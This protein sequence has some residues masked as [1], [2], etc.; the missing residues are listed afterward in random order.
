LSP[1]PSEL[2]NPVLMDFAYA[3]PTATLAGETLQDFV[4]SL[5]APN[6]TSMSLV[7]FNANI[8][9]LFDEGDQLFFVVTGNSGSL[10]LTAF[11]R[12][13]DALPPEPGS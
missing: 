13:G 11:D 3:T 7:D 5:T 9:P 10:E 6:I 1:G 8:D 4:V 12:D 2:S